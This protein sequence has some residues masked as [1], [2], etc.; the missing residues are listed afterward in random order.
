MSEGRK[1][2][3]ITHYYNSQNYGG[4]LQAYA[5]CKVVEQLNVGEVE[6]IC[7]DTKRVSSSKSAK[8]S[9][10]VAVRHPIKVLKAIKNKLSAHLV[11]ARDNAY[12]NAFEER[13]RA[14]KAFN[15][16]EIRHSDV[17]YNWQNIE[18]AAT[19]YDI[20]ITGSDQV[21][22]PRAMHPAYLLSFVKDKPK[23]SYAAS[24][25]C[26][27]LTEE[28]QE[29]FKIN[30]S[31]YINIS[32]REEKAKMLLTP[33]TKKEVRCVLDPTL[34]LDKEEWERI[35]VPIDICG[36]FAFCYFLGDD[37][38]SRELARHYAQKHGLILV[39]L[40]FMM[41]H[42]RKCDKKFGDKQLFNVTPQQFISLIKNAEIVFTD[43]FHAAVFANIFE[44]QYFVFLRGRDCS[45]NSRIYQLNT[46]F[47]QENKF[48]DTPQKKNLEYIEANSHSIKST[49]SQKIALA[50]KDSLEFLVDTLNKAR[51]YE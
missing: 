34:L 29:I 50:R 43:S 27:N 28:Q 46:L 16:D 49:T 41:G 47:G 24:I 37:M 38:Q 19:E 13:K 36:K 44:K 15:Q 21:W 3:V 20:F 32:V 4:N 5:L 6:Q 26:D 33:L 14:I 30:L 39:T 42:Y 51:K 1:I 7:Y 18:Q 48:C 17:V 10:M 25:A 22:N 12:R 40:P 11:A 2:G 23:F 31:D 35:S 9:L 45:M 8:K